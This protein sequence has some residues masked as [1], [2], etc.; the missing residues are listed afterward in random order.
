[1]AFSWSRKRRGLLLNECI[2]FSEHIQSKMSK[3]YKI[4]GLIK[5]LSSDLSRDAFLRF[6]SH[7]L[8]R[9]WIM[10]ISFT[11]NFMYHSK[12]KLR[13]FDINHL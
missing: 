1:M 2:N 12:I 7:L 8:D 4:I 9:L 11:A 10:V 5:K 13:V 3:C 6:I